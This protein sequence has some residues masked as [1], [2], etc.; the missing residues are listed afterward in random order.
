VV[1]G[2]ASI[3]ATNFKRGVG[4]VIF[5]AVFI[6]S[7]TTRRQ[8]RLGLWRSRRTTRRSEL[9]CCLSHNHVAA[10]SMSASATQRT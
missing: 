9:L 7:P 1:N 4:G 6:S 3:T 2:R 5:F 10:E 8:C